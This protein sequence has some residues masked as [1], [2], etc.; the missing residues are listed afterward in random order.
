ME[1]ALNGNNS[2]VAGGADD[3]VRGPRRSHHVTTT[4]LSSAHSHAVLSSAL[5]QVYTSNIFNIKI[6]FYFSDWLSFS[7]GSEILRK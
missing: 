1:L 2:M 6:F 3:T 4:G 5:N 7:V